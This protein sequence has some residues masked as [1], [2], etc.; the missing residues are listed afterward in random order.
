MTIKGLTTAS[1]L[2]TTAIIGIA[3]GSGYYYLAGF[4]AILVLVIL[5]I[6]SSLEKHFLP[7]YKTHTL[8]VVLQ[9][10]PGIVSYV[11]EVLLENNV[12]I[13][14][15]NASMPDKTTL[16]LNMVIRKPTDLGMDSVINLMNSIEETASMEIE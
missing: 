11:K 7:A 15:L 2:W 3:C 16:K 6:I 10:R 9:D 8:K 1:S 14:S 12:K 4:A 13:S 5:T